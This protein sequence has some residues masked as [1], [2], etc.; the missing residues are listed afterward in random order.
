M[1]FAL[2]LALLGFDAQ[3]RGGAQQQA[4]EADGFAD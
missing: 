4:L 3:G 2:F 1:F